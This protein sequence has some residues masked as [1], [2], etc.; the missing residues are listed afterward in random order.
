M[1]LIDSAGTQAML[2]NGDRQP[3]TSDK[4]ILGFGLDFSK[5]IDQDATTAS[6][7]NGNVT[8]QNYRKVFQPN[9]NNNN[10]SHNTTVPE[11]A[12]VTGAFPKDQSSPKA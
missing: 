6:L 3:R 9:M 5:L 10:L 8:N 7:V 11:E 4:E 12:E 2:N 1:D